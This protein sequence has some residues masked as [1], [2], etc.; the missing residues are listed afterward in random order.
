MPVYELTEAA[1]ADVQAIARYT[2]KTWGIEQARRYEAILESHFQAIGREKA[3]ARGFLKHRPE[4]RI[5]RIEHHDVFHLLRANQ[6]PLILAVLHE[7]MDL[8]NR[9][10]DRLDS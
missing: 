1:D 2:V 5:S 3:R 4:L 10:R 8:V 7:N 9:L 6:G